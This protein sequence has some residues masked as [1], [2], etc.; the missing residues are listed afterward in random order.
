MD[1]L[2]KAA[3]I[4][5]EGNKHH[6]KQMDILI[7]NGIINSIEPNID[8]IDCKIIKS[9]NLCVST[10]WI[11][12]HANFQDPGFEYKEDLNSGIKAAAA[13]GFTQVCI[14]PLTNPVIDNKSSVDYII[15]KTKGA[16]VNI[17]P[18]GCLSSKAEGKELAELYDM[19][20]AG[21]IGFTD[22]KKS[23]SNPNLINRA[24]MYTQAFNGLILAYPHTTEVAD[25]G[26]MNEGEINT[27]LGLKGIPELAEDLMVERDLSIAEYTNGR[28][29]F[30]TV[31][32]KRS[33]ELIKSAKKKGLKVTCDIASY[34]IS[35]LDLELLEFDSRFKLMPP[36]RTKDT[37][38]SLIKGIKEG[39]IDAISS[40][41]IPEDIDEK[42]K[43]LDYAAFGMINLQTA[44]AAANTATKGK[45]PN[46]ELIKLFTSGPAKILGLKIEP[47]KIGE[48]A[49]LTL[50]D[51]KAK[52]E[53]TK[54]KVL[55]KS[56]NSPY[57]NR[58]LIGEVIGIVNN[59]KSYFN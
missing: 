48:K 46:S 9:K 14:S 30:S 34:S 23:I 41:H 13:G 27:Q 3:T 32:S 24:L 25:K 42:M 7:K 56:K 43:E 47:I 5:C 18:Y 58:N 15:N 57:F 16:L 21:A 19:K 29:H 35:M 28:I 49:N 2:I 50:F 26:I 52:F 8:A 37:A 44:Y 36:L 59:K 54:D 12:M 39:V 10:G 11:D 17:H 20:Q 40:D 1:I 4:V 38:D 55:S 33:I 22:D 31:S 45:V 51:P 53:F 6:G